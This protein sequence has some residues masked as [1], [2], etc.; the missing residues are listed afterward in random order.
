MQHGKH[1]VSLLF[2]K[3][4]CITVHSEIEVFKLKVKK[5]KNRLLAAN[6]MFYSNLAFNRQF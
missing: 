6:L 1:I 2:Q 4:M 5:R 3:H